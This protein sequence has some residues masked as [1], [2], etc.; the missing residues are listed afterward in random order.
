MEKRSVFVYSGSK[1]LCCIKLAFDAL[2]SV[3]AGAA[4]AG[5]L[6]SLAWRHGPGRPGR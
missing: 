6:V 5:L 4:A 2:C 3:G 1:I